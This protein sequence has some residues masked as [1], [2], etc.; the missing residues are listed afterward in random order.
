MHACEKP[1][2]VF[3]PL[4]CH[5]RNAT[6]AAMA[7]I[8]CSHK[9]IK[10]MQRKIFVLPINSLLM[11]RNSSTLSLSV[12]RNSPL[13][14]FQ[15]VRIYYYLGCRLPQI[16]GIRIRIDWG[17]SEHQFE[18]VRPQRERAMKLLPIAI[19]RILHAHKRASQSLLHSLG[20]GR[21]GRSRRETSLMFAMPDKQ[22][23]DK[24][25]RKHSHTCKRAHERMKMPKMRSNWCPCFVARVVG[26]VACAPCA[27]ILT[28][29]RWNYSYEC[30][31][32][33]NWLQIERVSIHRIEVYRWGWWWARRVIWH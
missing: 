15:R 7:T 18:C 24:S 10:R 28:F 5:P 21:A 23:L 16:Y 25:H 30:Y 13:C 3:H 4:F 6:A 31:A 19:W 12:T 20:C 17:N 1:L 9:H 2:C 33:A 14:F 29:S 27:R 22:P 32:I 11:P 8:V 26:G